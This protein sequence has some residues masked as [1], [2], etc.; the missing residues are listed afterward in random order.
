MKP[1]KNEEN[2][3]FKVCFPD[4]AGYPYS[5][6]GYIVQRIVLEQ[7]PTITLSVLVLVGV[8]LPPTS[9]TMMGLF[10]D[11]MENWNWIRKIINVEINMVSLLECQCLEPAK[12]IAEEV[13]F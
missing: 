6:M 8:G 13:S 4:A 9:S 3:S 12:I 2:L 1:Q 7:I 5:L 11:L 10:M